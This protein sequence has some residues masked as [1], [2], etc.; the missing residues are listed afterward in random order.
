MDRSL[1]MPEIVQAICD[2]LDGVKTALSVALACKAFEDPGLN[3]VWRSIQTLRPIL[4]LLPWGALDYVM[5][6]QGYPTAVSG[7]T[8]AIDGPLPLNAVLNFFR[9]DRSCATPSADSI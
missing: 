8:Q 7:K 4:G 6:D 2:V 5:D 1:Q 9:F 3:R